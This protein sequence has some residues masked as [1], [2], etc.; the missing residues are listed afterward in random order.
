MNPLVSLQR[1]CTPG[2]KAVA[3]PMMF[4]RGGA[5]SFDLV[6]NRSRGVL[7]ILQP[8]K[9]RV[10]GM[11][12]QSCVC[13]SVPLLPLSLSRSASTESEHTATTQRCQH[14]VFIVGCFPADL[15][16]EL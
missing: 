1:E 3:A 2:A 9:K 8:S 14:V 4:G 7:C 16:N 11:C 10:T 15:T 5:K 6:V 12:A 13:I